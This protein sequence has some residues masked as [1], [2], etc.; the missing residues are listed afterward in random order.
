MPSKGF[1]QKKIRNR[2]ALGQRHGSVC[3]LRNLNNINNKNNKE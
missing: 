3:Y 1:A 2:L